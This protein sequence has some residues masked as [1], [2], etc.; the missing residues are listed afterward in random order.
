MID[1]NRSE[2]SLL[3]LSEFWRGSIDECENVQAASKSR[4]GVV[5]FG[6]PDSLSLQETRL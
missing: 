3:Q 6:K 4:C 5:G 1:S 2:K